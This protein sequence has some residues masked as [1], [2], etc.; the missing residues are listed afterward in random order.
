[1]DL[2]ELAMQLEDCGKAPDALDDDQ[3][4]RTGGASTRALCQ[5]ASNNCLGTGVRWAGTPR[6]RHYCVKRRPGA[7]PAPPRPLVRRTLIPH[8]AT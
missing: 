7:A 2:S 3:Q 6:S 1:M 8:L 4:V 5:G